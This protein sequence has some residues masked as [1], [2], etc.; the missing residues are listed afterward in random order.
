MKTIEITLNNKTHRISCSED[1][2]ENV[3]NTSKQLEEKI[4]NLKKAVPRL[5]YEMAYVITLLQLQNEVNKLQNN[6]PS[7]ILDNPPKSDE[8]VKQLDYVTNFLE[9]LAKKYN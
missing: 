4:S 8:D 3:L 2:I 7:E 6:S 5:N 1:D 9:E